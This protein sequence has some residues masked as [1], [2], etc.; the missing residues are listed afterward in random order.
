M[1]IPILLCSWACLETLQKRGIHLPIIECLSRK[2]PETC[3][4]ETTQTALCS[5]LSSP[6]HLAEAPHS[7]T[8]EDF[9]PMAE[10]RSQIGP[11]SLWQRPTPRQEQ[12]FL[13]PSLQQPISGTSQG[14]LNFFPPSAAIQKTKGPTVLNPMR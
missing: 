9:F 6:E 11:N 14:K 10:I 8:Q 7:P 1:M 13:C 4:K 3:R 5:Q 2:S 12:G